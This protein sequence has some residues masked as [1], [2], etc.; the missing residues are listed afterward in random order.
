[1]KFKQIYLPVLLSALII[2]T[3]VGAM[4]LIHNNWV[5]NSIEVK[6][7]LAAK[8]TNQPNT[9]DLKTIIHESQKNVVQIEA[10]GNWSEKTGSGFLY[11]NKGDIITNAHVVKDAD[12]ITVKM[13][14]AQTYPAAIV[15]VGDSIDIA[16]IRVP[17]LASQTPFAI[18]KQYEAEIG[19]E[20]VALGS[21]LGFQNSVSLGI[22]SGTNRTFTID[23]FEYENVYQISAPIT[24]GNSGGPLIDQTTGKVVA[25]NSAGTDDGGI[26][27]SIPITHV[28]EYVEEW[29]NEADNEELVYK[30]TNSQEIDTDQLEKDAE[31]IIHYF[32]DNLA[33]RDYLNAYAMLGSDWQTRTT[34]QAFREDYFYIVESEIIQ[35][36]QTFL[37]QR[38]QV[39]LNVEVDTTIRQPNQETETKT[40]QYTFFVGYENDQLKIIDGVREE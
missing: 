19:N 17:Q 26:G 10:E 29:S 1:M 18:D 22:I 8:I 11:N 39:Q 38:N 25:I 12:F 5:G 40:Y 32:F 20:I 30:S 31:Y 28:L 35:I 3:G 24:H 33:I 23:E 6:N 14:N 37:E 4:F 36:T 34:Y 21:P 27:F 9:K 15:G 16:V 7:T 13:A 2:T